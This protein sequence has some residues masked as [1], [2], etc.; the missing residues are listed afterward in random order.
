[1]FNI[2]NSKEKYTDFRMLFKKE[3]IESLDPEIEMVI[4]G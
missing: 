1:M 4:K 2:K 3:F